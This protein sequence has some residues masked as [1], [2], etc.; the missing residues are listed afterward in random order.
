MMSCD[1][2]I[3][4]SVDIPIHRQSGPCTKADLKLCY[5]FGNTGEYS[6]GKLSLPGYFE[7]LLECVDE[8]M[9][10]F[11]SK[12]VNKETAIHVIQELAKRDV[13]FE[14]IYSREVHLVEY[15]RC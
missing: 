12:P 7:T 8:D 2:D 6:V 14:D 13:I 1:G 11:V 15:P 4:L 10:S 5:P 3:S 9:V